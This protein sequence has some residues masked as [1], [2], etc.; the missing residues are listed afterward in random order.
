M[1]EGVLVEVEARVDE[2]PQVVLDLGLI[3][4]CRGHDGGIEDV[5]LLVDLVAVVQDPPGGLGAAVAN[6]GAG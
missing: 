3:L 5:T 4:R 6:S 2:V 1:G